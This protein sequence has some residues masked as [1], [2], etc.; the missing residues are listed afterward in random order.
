MYGVSNMSVYERVNGY[1]QT[2]YEFVGEPSELIG[3]ID[4]PE[5]VELRFDAAGL[6][7]P[8]YKGRLDAYGLSYIDGMQAS[9]LEGLVR[10]DNG[11]W[12][13]YD[14]LRNPRWFPVKF[15]PKA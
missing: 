6:P 11:S 2:V 4:L 12:L 1:G 14:D 3:T 15:H 5:G 8:Y 7:Y 13:L 10:R 9:P